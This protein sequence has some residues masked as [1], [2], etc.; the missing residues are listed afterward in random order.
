[1]KVTLCLVKHQL[2]MV[3]GGVK[4]QN[5]YFTNLLLQIEMG[6]QLHTLV[7]LHR[8]NNPLNPPPLK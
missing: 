8:G 6:C 1:M 4:I 7:A 3:Y 2:I 5:K